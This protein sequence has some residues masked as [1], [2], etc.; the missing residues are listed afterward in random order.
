MEKQEALNWLNYRL[1]IE[2]DMGR[3]NHFTWTDLNF[4]TDFIRDRTGKE[5][6]V[7]HLINSIRVH[8][9]SCLSWVERLINH[10]VYTFDIQ[11][12]TEKTPD[13]LFNMR[14][15]LDINSLKI[16]KYY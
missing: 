15:G 3:N 4:F 2:R 9:D 6:E 7:M 8:S 5:V 16:L 13:L 11:M 12:E 14:F 1:K 10:L